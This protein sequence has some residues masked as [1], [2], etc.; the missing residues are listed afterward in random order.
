[1]RLVAA[2]GK[3]VPAEEGDGRDD[4][5]QHDGIGISGLQG[6]EEEAEAQGEKEDVQGEDGI[7]QMR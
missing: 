4:P 5:E 6:E 3:D 2:Q 7:G 1:M